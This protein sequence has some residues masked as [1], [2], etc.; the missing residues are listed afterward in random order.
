[1]DMIF[2]KQ[3]C[4]MRQ[5]ILDPVTVHMYRMTSIVKFLQNYRALNAFAL[6]IYMIS[7]LCLMLDENSH[8]TALTN[9]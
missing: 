6:E 1:M 8:V 4:S 7:G 5:K 2:D 9:K 3:M